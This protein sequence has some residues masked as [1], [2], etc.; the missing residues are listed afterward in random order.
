MP[1]QERRK[2]ERR[3]GEDRRKFDRGT[4]DR[5]KLDRRKED[6]GEIFEDQIE[7]RNAVIELLE[8]D[9]DVNKIY[10]TKGEKVRFNK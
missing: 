10:V 7:G 3:K 1:K 2:E 8:S 9:K 6:K 5:R 4:G